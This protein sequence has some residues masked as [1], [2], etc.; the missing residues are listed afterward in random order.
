MNN[1]VVKVANYTYSW[2][3]VNMAQCMRV[4]KARGSALSAVH[5]IL[6]L[7]LAM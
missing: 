2:A 4:L 5:C 7:S 6:T 3:N 1:K